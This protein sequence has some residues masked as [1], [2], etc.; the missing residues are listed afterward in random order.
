[1]VMARRGADQLQ[2]DWTSS[3]TQA[4]I[5]RETLVGAGAAFWRLTVL[6]SGLRR[7]T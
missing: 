1:M 4:R 7:A 2:A 5:T 3:I 6:N